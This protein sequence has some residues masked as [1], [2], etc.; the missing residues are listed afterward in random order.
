MEVNSQTSTRADDE[1]VTVF[2]KIVAG[3]LPCDKLYEDDLVMAFRDIN[4]TAQTHFLVIPKQRD[5]LT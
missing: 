5:G 1:Q 2:D 4:P 3:E